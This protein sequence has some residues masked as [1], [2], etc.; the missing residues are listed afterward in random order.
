MIAKKPIK[1]LVLGSLMIAL[2][3][4]LILLMGCS[5]GARH[6]YLCGGFRYECPCV[7]EL[8]TGNIAEL[9]P[10]NN[11]K[12]IFTSV[13]K[14]SARSSEQ[15]GVTATV[16]VVGD[17]IDRKKF[18]DNCLGIIDRTPNGGYV[19]ADLNEL[20]NIAL[21]EIKDG[22]ELQIRDCNITIY[23]DQNNQLVL[24]TAILR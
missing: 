23:E 17:E 7:I 18:C 24:E 19:L 4:L 21:Y 1:K 11:G 12:A 2:A 22:I 5:G 9:K 10:A 8:S 15:N 6:C 3:A 14:I 16:P 20:D 13:G